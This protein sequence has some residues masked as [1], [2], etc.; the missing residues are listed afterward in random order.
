ML[1]DVY[2]LKKMDPFN[3]S[4]LAKSATGQ[5]LY[6]HNHQ[7][8]QIHTC[9]PKMGKCSI[10]KRVLFWLQRSMICTLK[11]NKTILL[12]VPS[13]EIFPQQTQ[14]KDKNLVCQLNE[15]KKK[16]QQRKTPPP[17][18][19]SLTFQKIIGCIFFI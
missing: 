15:C 9:I 6:T 17:T 19:R 18:G 5:L 4:Y 14:N 8:A 12:V 1:L 10:N 3:I 7:H 13:Q 11:K 2:F 16:K